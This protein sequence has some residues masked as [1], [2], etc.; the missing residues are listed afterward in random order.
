[1]I[2]CT[3]TIQ[4]T[5]LDAGDIERMHMGAKKL[6]DGR[7]QYKGKKYASKDE[8]P[9]EKI[10]GVF[11]NKSRGRGWDRVG[12]SQIFFEDGRSHTF[13]EH[14]G[15][16]WISSKEVTYGAGSFNSV[17]KHLVYAGGLAKTYSIRNGK[18]RHDYK[19]T[20]SKEQEWELICAVKQEI[21]KHPDI[22]IIGHNSVKSK[23]CPCFSVIE[24]CRMIG[25]PEENIDTRK[26]KVRLKNPTTTHFPDPDSRPFNTKAEGDKFRAW[27]NKHHVEYAREIDLDP[28]G[29][30]TNAYIMK[31][32]K[33]LKNEYKEYLTSA[34]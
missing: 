19:N 16:N 23:G 27:V 30:H 33:K 15:D 24:W 8:L 5:K 1:M 18:K 12:Y 31:A 22:K 4:G 32:Y 7:I 14:D 26:L 20:M 25:V 28:K 29:S 2:H 11:A 21:R 6:P 3:A 34:S 13:V 10:G 17:T 9:D